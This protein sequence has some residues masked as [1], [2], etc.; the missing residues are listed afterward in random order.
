[1]QNCYHLHKSI[2]IRRL[3]WTHRKIRTV[4]TN[5]MKKRDLQ[6]SVKRS[7]LSSIIRFMKTVI[8]LF[9]VFYSLILV[10]ALPEIM[11][12]AR[13][14][15]GNEIVSLVHMYWMQ[16]GQVRLPLVIAATTP[17][18]IMGPR[19]VLLYK[20]PCLIFFK[21]MRKMAAVFESLS[22]TWRIIF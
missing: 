21:K 7:C 6:R 20:R 2:I 1:M 13:K 5:F 22:T 16:W 17:S 3:S 12:I 18:I 10:Q 15:L 11:L 9:Y 14:G 19:F 8:F 4:R